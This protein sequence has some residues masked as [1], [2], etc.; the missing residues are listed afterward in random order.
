MLSPLHTLPL[1]LQAPPRR[2]ICS[3][4]LLSLPAFQAHATRGKTQ[5][6]KNCA[7]SIAGP[8]WTGGLRDSQLLE[9][10]GASTGAEGSGGGGSSSSRACSSILYTVW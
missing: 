6:Q 4:Q 1:L 8:T 10:Y 7:G 3:K 5:P 2:V 9:I